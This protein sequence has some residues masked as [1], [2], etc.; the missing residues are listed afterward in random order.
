MCAS[1]RTP[2][3]RLGLLAIVVEKHSLANVAQV[4][5]TADAARLLL[6]IAQHD[7]EQPEQVG[8][9]TESADNHARDRDPPS[10]EA[11]VAGVDFA[12]T[13]EA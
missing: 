1:D 8:C 2:R 7:N 10:F 6:Q 12:E 13:E 9:G 5:L 11:T 4:V 3:K